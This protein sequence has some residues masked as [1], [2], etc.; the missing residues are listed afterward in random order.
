LP[1]CTCERQSRCRHLNVLAANYLDLSATA[2]KAVE[3]VARQ[4]G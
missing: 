4:A 2:T 3:V 1:E